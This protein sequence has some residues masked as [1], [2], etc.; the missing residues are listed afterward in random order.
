MMM[1]CMLFFC[2]F[3]FRG[4]IIASSTTSP[5][6]PSSIL[7]MWPPQTLKKHKRSTW[8]RSV[9]GEIVFQKCQKNMIIYE[10]ISG[11]S[12]W[13]RVKIPQDQFS[14]ELLNLTL[15]MNETL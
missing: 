14:R 10:S 9:L 1:Y 15:Y 8:L 6:L 3:N 4:G 13:A 2:F 7:A 11:F 12:I 5:G